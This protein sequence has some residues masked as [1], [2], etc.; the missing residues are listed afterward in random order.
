MGDNVPKLATLVHTLPPAIKAELHARLYAANFGHLVATAA[1]L[2][3]KGY[4]AKKSALQAYCT[5][6]REG[7]ELAVAQSR[8]KATPAARHT[9]EVRL[10]CLEAAASTGPA[11]STL[12]RAAQYSSWVFAGETLQRPRGR[13]PA[14]KKAAARKAANGRKAP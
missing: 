10:R 9:E 12:K 5:A 13:G 3:S 4:P 11:V 7:I 6:N 1:W 14:A 8:R 2:T